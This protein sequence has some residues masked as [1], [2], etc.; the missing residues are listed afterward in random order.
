ML[1][2]LLAD[3]APMVMCF[4]LG[5]LLYHELVHEHWH[6]FISFLSGTGRKRRPKLPVS[7]LS[8][9]ANGVRVHG[10]TRRAD[11]FS[12]WRTTRSRNR[13]EPTVL[14]RYPFFLSARTKIRRKVAARDF[15]L[16]RPEL[17]GRVQRKTQPALN[18]NEL[19]ES[20]DRSN[21]V[22]K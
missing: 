13:E 6:G 2:E 9:A 14:L 19:A 16:F 21:F 15:S 8:C 20:F 4:R 7:S 11:L 22:C 10:R 1:P 12:F 5:D 18:R 17:F 3:G